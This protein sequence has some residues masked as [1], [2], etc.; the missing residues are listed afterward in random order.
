MK[1]I[2]WGADGEVTDVTPVDGKPFTL[3]QLQKFVG[4]LIEPYTF[5]DGTEIVMNEEARLNDNQVVNQKATELWL[6]HFP[7]DKFPENNLGNI[8]GD[9][10]YMEDYP[11]D[12]G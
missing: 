1:V 8:I 5:P 12:R 2:F 10:L 4:G 6:K 9:V 11:W 3:A 7:L